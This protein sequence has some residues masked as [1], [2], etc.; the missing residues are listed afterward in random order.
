L[1]KE[2]EEY[3]P[4]YIRKERIYPNTEFS[5]DSMKDYMWNRWGIK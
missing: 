4:Y 3:E 2:G 5:D 1:A